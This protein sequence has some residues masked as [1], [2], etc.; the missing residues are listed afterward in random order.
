MPHSLPPPPSHLAPV[1]PHYLQRHG[2]PR[3][4]CPPEEPRRILK[5]PPARTSYYPA[6][7]TD[8]PR[9]KAQHHQPSRPREGRRAQE[10]NKL[11]N[12]PLNPAPSRHPQ[13]QVPFSSR[14]SAAIPLLPL[15]RR[16]QRLRWR[17]LLPARNNSH[18]PA[19]TALF[20][21]WAAAAAGGRE[22]SSARLRMRSGRKAVSAARAWGLPAQRGVRMRSPGILGEVD[23]VAG[24]SL[25]YL[26]C[27]CGFNFLFLFF[28]R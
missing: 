22:E 21:H 13:P 23:G 24:C 1:G 8:A 11:P 12:R 9:A 19:C 6:L 26:S 17:R 27:V 7:L 4:T 2:A 3:S 28:F 14:L 10:E 16:A 25:L 5:P 15:P 18:S 20:T